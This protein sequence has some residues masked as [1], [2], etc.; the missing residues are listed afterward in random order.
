MLQNFDFVTTN[1]SKY[2]SVIL[3]TDKNTDI[4]LISI[5]EYGGDYAIVTSKDIIKKKNLLP[6]QKLIIL[7]KFDS[8]F[9]NVH[10]ELYQEIIISFVLS[11][12]LITN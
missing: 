6:Y 10:K 7:S 4:K 12:D 11:S 8:W 2:P 9:Y 5:V 3:I 1:N